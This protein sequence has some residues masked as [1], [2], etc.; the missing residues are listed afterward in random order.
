MQKSISNEQEPSKG[1]QNWRSR[2]RQDIKDD[3]FQRQAERILFDSN[4][5]NPIPQNRTQPHAYF[6]SEAEKPRP[7]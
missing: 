3:L 7:N 5:D 6:Q 2:R 1:E 4:R